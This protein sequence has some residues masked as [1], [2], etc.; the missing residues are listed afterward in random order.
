MSFSLKAYAEISFL[1]LSLIDVSQYLK[2]P[3]ITIIEFKN[4]KP[5]QI[6]T[7]F[8]LEEACIIVSLVNDDKLVNYS[9]SP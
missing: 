5:K 6:Q 7:L 8:G 4:T 2:T 3:P 9:V 1:A